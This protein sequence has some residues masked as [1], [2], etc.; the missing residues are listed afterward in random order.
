[1]LRP[2]LALLVIAFAA[3]AGKTQDP[4][5][6]GP[7]VNLPEV[8]GFTKQKA[9]TY[10]STGLGW[11]VTYNGARSVATVFVYNMDR[12]EI[13]TGADSDVIKAEMYEVICGLE[14]GKGTVYKSIVPL[15]DGAAPLG[16]GKTGTRF[17]FKRYE[18]DLNKVGPVI[19]EIHLTGWKN[20]FVKIHVTYKVA[21]AEDAEEEL[22]DLLPALGRAFR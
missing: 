7:R 1:M 5:L 11:S 2:A 6:P 19:T 18:A 13:P 17:R 8:D 12:D 15:K 4:K 14:G 10:S 21:D 20:Y 22:K 9:K 16:G 3:V